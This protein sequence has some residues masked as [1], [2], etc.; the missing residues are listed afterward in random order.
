MLNLSCN[1]HF[2]RAFTA[3]I[4]IFKVITLAGSNQCNYFKYANACSKC[5]LKTTVATQLNGQTDQIIKKSSLITL[6]RKMKKC[7]FGVLE[8]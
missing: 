6:E 7:N 3:C 2:Y 5:M 1:S 4:C 8:N